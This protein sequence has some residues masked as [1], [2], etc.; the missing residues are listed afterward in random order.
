MRDGSTA[1]VSMPLGSLLEAGIKVWRTSNGCYVTEGIDGRLPARF[2][3]SVLRLDDLARLWPTEDAAVNLA[4][5]RD[6]VDGTYRDTDKIEEECIALANKLRSSRRAEDTTR[7]IAQNAVDEITAARLG[8]EAPDQS[9]SLQLAQMSVELPARGE[10][11]TEPLPEER[12]DP[13]D[14]RSVEPAIPET[15][16]AAG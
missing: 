10:V 1:V 9:L 12:G 2:I 5:Q 8:E 13:S 16:K 14:I 7:D 11:E 4:V 3:S 15:E 6:Q